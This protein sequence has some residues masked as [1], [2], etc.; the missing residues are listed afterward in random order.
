MKIVID[1]NGALTEC[2]VSGH[3]YENPTM[4]YFDE[5][6]ETCDESTQR[7]VIEAMEEVIKEWRKEAEK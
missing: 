1:T 5:P 4:P 3:T 2:R 6:L 7:R